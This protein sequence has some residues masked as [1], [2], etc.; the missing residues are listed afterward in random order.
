MAYF[1][2]LSA[3]EP[4]RSVDFDFEIHEDNT[5]VVELV[6]LVEAG[7]E[8]SCER[9]AR[10]VEGGLCDCMVGRVEVESDY[11]SN[12]CVELVGSIDQVAVCSDY[13]AVGR[14]C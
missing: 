11:V 1:D 13:H 2:S 9:R 5:G 8:T 14:F 6:D 7:V 12:S 4:E 10:S 3:V